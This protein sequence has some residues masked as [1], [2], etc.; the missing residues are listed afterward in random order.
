[1][2]SNFFKF[3]NG[4]VYNVDYI[5]SAKRYTTESEF[6]FKED[7]GTYSLHATLQ[8]YDNFVERFVVI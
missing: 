7:G 8:D 5:I 1:M 6:T 3:E 2:N 4:M